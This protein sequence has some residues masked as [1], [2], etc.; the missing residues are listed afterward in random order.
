MKYF[1]QT[2]KMP[3]SMTPYGNNSSAAHRV[4]AGD[5]QI[6]YE[7]YGQGDPIVILHGGGLG[8]PYEMC[9]IIDR[10][11]DNHQMIVVSTRG[12]GR[13]EIGHSP[14]TLD[15]RADDI[16]SVLNDAHINKPVKIIGFSDGGYSSYAFA[17]KYPDAVNRIATI[18][19][20]EVLLTNKFFVFDL[21]AWKQFDA[22][23]IAQQQALMPEPDR[24]REMLHMYEDMWNATVV[25][26]ELLS[27]VKCPV[28]LV[29]GER[30]Q[31]S[32]MLTA[33]AA[34]YEL[35]DA[36]LSIIPNAPHQCQ[37]THFDAVWAVVEPF[38]EE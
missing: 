2:S 26:K 13:S 1:G 32:P 15:Q 31:N 12:H 6:Y 14:F 22:E 28:L 21:D 4:L 16:H 20:G 17:A 8:C 27:K 34:Y 19:A 35:P 9:G 23:F 36:Q 33:L 25:S 7:L 24:W 29:N 5:A 18:G 10:L 11:K 37:V 30:D 38:I 3:S